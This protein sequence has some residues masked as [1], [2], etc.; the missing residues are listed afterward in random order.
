MVHITDPARQK[1]MDLMQAH[2]RQDLA[3]RL[4]IRG[5]GPRGCH[6]DCGFVLPEDRGEGDHVIE[7][8]GFQLV[9]DPESASHLEGATLDYVEQ[10]GHGGFKIDNP[11]PLWA[12]P[13]ARA[14][15]E[16]IDQRINP[17]VGMHGG[18]VTLLSVKDGVAYIALGGGCQG[19]GLAD[20]TLRQGI[21]VL[22]RESVPEIH[23]VV[24]TTE[25][26]AG[27]NPYYPRSKAGES[28]L[29]G[30][31]SSE[32]GQAGGTARP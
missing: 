12:D 27:A 28:P 6:D 19:C 11:N 7:A 10:Q 29:A 15:Q 13:V 23:Q 22:I 5:R 21:D 20:V 1:I 2:G 26:A 24:D 8:G 17:G 25:H 3:V 30:T 31:H 16:V 4:A 14:V 32:R 9:I 18:L